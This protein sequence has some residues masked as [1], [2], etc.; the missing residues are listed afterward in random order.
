M[1][2]IRSRGWLTFWLVGLGTVLALL[3]AVL[4]I[5]GAQEAAVPAVIA[6]LW[7]SLPAWLNLV[8]PSLAEKPAERAAATAAPSPARDPRAAGDGDPDS[9]RDRGDLGAGNI[10]ELV[11][12]RLGDG[13]ISDLAYDHFRPVYRQFTAGMSKDEKARRLVEYANMQGREQ[14]LHEQVRKLNPGAYDAWRRRPGDDT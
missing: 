7:G 2:T 14:D 4:L 11:A 3:V 6:G 10:R 12:E 9:D 5:Y 13:Q 1:G 8:F